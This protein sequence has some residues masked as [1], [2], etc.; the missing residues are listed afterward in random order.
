[1]DVRIAA[2]A[3]VASGAR[4]RGRALLAGGS[5]AALTLLALLVTLIDA[6]GTGH[7]IRMPLGRPR[8]PVVIDMRLVDGALDPSLVLLAPGAVRFSVRNDGSG[9]RR[10][11]V[12]GS[13]LR[14]ETDTLPP[15]AT[16][17]L[18][19]T[20]ATPGRYAL[21]AASPS[22]ETLAAGTLEIRRP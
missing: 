18:E 9:P 3:S 6:T 11:V 22:G 21:E 4:R 12:A 17:I 10:F 5:I 19:I 15:G 8:R 13:G 2:R 14:G 16:A 7:G 1:M 20:L